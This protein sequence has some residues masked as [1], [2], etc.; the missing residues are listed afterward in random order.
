MRHVVLRRG[1]ARATCPRDQAPGVIADPR[2]LDGVAPIPAEPAGMVG[3]RGRPPLGVATPGTTG[4]TGFTGRKPL[5]FAV[6]GGA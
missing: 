3:F 2:S 6:N 5:N 1:A 4:L